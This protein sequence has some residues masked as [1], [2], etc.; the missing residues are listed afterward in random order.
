MG[1]LAGCGEGQ[2]V[3]LQDNAGLSSAKA[4]LSAASMSCY[5]DTPAFDELRPNHCW[6]I[7]TSP[8]VAVFHLST[9]TPAAYVVWYDHPECSGHDCAVSIR[10]GQSITLGAYYVT[11]Q[12]TPTL[13]AGATAEYSY[14]Y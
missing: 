1:F 7:G 9:P 3:A 8:S 5:I 10:P 13:G 12:G 2:D 6:A 14:N 11:Y 4:E